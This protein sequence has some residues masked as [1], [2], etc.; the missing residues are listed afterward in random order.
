MKRNITHKILNQWDYDRNEGITPK[1]LLAGLF[2]HKAFWWICSEGHRWQAKYTNAVPKCAVCDHIERSLLKVNPA[3][4]KEWHPTKN[5]TLGPVDVF[6][7][8]RK[9]IWWLCKK[10]HEW[11]SQIN[12]RNASGSLCPFCAGKKACKENCLATINPNLT[13]QWHPTKNG[14]LTPKDVTPKS[15]KKVWWQCT[16]GHEW[17]ANVYDRDHGDSCPYCACRK[18]CDD[19][20]LSNVNP[21]LSKEWHLT[22]NGRLRPQDVVYGS[23]KKVWWRCFVGH[24]WQA[25]IRHRNAGDGCPYCSGRYSSI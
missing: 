8:S 15:N 14:N 25:V 17:Q 4:A 20:S 19:N 13:K 10:K 22:K 5:E 7:S 16:S 2:L 12:S 11:E 6:P 1:D 9:K 18:V 24:S 23:T 21:Q 3:L